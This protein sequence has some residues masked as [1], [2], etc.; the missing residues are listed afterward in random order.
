[1]LAVMLAVSW[2][3]FPT[4][5]SSYDVQNEVNFFEGWQN[6]SQRKINP[7]KQPVSASNH[8]STNTS[9]SG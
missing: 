6:N 7:Q 9:L 1:M 3:L 8:R 4:S 5:K 2:L